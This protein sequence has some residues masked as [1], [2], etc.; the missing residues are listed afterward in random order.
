MSFTG[1]VAKKLNL[2]LTDLT[3]LLPSYFMPSLTPAHIHKSLISSHR[4][5]NLTEVRLIHKYIHS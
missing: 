5:G 1:M 3:P 4:Y 2:K